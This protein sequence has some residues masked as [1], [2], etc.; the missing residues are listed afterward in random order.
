MKNVPTRRTCTLLSTRSFGSVFLSCNLFPDTCLRCSEDS[1]GQGVCVLDFCVGGFNLGLLRDL[2]FVGGSSPL[3]QIF[4]FL[5][6]VV[7]CAC[8]CSLHLHAVSAQEAQVP[9]D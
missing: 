8:L 4:M 3:F 2:V 7:L 6:I 1:V 9:I 5:F